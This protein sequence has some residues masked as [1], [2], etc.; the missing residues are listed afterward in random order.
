[1][2]TF[3]EVWQVFSTG[4]GALNGLDAISLSAVFRIAE[5]ELRGE[6]SSALSMRDGFLKHE[7]RVIGREISQAELD[8]LVQEI[9]EHTRF[10]GTI[11][12]NSDGARRYENLPDVGFTITDRG[13]QTV[14]LTPDG[15]VPA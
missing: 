2:F 4:K 3:Q 14:V 9:K 5:K 8:Q 6:T 15:L 1:M 10:E 11:V 12:Y 7:S 13:F